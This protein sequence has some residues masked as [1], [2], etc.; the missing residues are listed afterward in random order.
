M[1]KINRLAVVF[2]EKNVTNR[3]ISEV[4]NTREET[5]S[6]WVNNKQQP[7]IK[8]MHEIANYLKVDIRD[9]FYPSEWAK[10]NKDK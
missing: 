3:L 8:T 7:S 5:V 1:E 4:T 2:K 6:R 9:L 10:E